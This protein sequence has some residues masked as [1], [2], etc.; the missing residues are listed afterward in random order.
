MVESWPASQQEGKLQMILSRIE[1]FMHQLFFFGGGG[2]GLGL[3]FFASMKA[4]GFTGRAC[5][6]QGTIQTR[7]EDLAL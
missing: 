2:V 3:F 1:Y 7:K 5:G 6:D 4:S